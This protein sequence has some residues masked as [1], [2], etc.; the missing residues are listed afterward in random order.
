MKI[1]DIVGIILFFIIGFLFIWLLTGYCANW[2]K[3]WLSHIIL[4]R[5][6]ASLTSGFSNVLLYCFIR[7]LSY[8]EQPETIS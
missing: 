2:E 8:E 7:I 3:E 4:L 5:I 6:F 1:I